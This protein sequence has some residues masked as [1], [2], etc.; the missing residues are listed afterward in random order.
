MSVVVR[1][2]TRGVSP[3]TLCK[4]YHILRTPEYIFAIR[5]RLSM[6][7]GGQR[8]LIDRRCMTETNGV[9]P[10]LLQLVIRGGGGLNACLKRTFLIRG[11]RKRAH[12]RP[13]HLGVD[14]SI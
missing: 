13:L 2:A 11:P 12:A 1:G 4:Q 14:W 7:G 9:M 6:G 10:C 3:Y 5:F 8:R